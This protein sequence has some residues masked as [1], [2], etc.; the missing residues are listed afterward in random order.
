V[1][2]ACDARSGPRGAYR[3]QSAAGAAAAI[4]IP[5]IAIGAEAALAP[6]PASVERLVMPSCD[7]AALLSALLTGAVSLQL[8]TLSLAHLVG[9]NPDLIRREQRTYREAA[10]VAETRADW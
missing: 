5:T 7:G 4:G 6:L 2:F 9:S 1:L 10:S 3:L 8:L